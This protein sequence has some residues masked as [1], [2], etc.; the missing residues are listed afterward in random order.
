MMGGIAMFNLSKIKASYMYFLI[1]FLKIVDVS[2]F[3]FVLQFCRLKIDA[4]VIVRTWGLIEEK[5]AK[6]I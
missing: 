1:S 2:T 4:N 5:N 6:K 3:L